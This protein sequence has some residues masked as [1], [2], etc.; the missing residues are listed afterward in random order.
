VSAE[1]RPLIVAEPMLRAPSPEIVSE[2]NLASC[3]KTPG[4]NP[5]AR[6]MATIADVRKKDVRKNLLMIS[7]PSWYGKSFVGAR[8]AAHQLAQTDGLR[9]LFPA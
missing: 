2:S 7:V 3:A 4:A 1:I 5:P 8:H 6:R 9:R